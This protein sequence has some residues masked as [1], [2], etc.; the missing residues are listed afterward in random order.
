MAPIISA[1]VQLMAWCQTGDKTLPEA[2][3]TRCL[4]SYVVTREPFIN[5]VYFNPSMDK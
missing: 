1:S 5:M 4:T 2:M 3:L